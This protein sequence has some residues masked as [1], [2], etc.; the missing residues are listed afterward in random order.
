MSSID[1]FNLVGTVVA[2]SLMIERVLGSGTYG[3]V[4][5]AVDTTSPEREEFAVK[6][7]R[8]APPGHQERKFQDREIKLHSIV[9]DHPNIITTHGTFREGPYLL[10]IM[11]YS[12]G[13]DLYDAIHQDKMLF[14]DDKRTKHVLL[15]VI[16]ALEAC[17]SAGVYHG[18]LKTENI[19]CSQDLS[20][21]YLTDFGLSTDKAKCY[22]CPRGTSMYMAPGKFKIPFP[23]SISCLTVIVVIIESA[24]PLFGERHVSSDL[25]DIWALGAMIIFMI[26]GLVPWEQASLS[27]PEFRNFLI[28]PYYLQTWIPI[29]TPAQRL[30]R[31]ILTLDPA[32]RPSLEKI[33]SE[34]TKMP[35]FYMADREIAWASEDVKATKEYF[36]L[37]VDRP[38]FFRTEQHSGASAQTDSTIESSGGLVTPL[39]APPTIEP[40]MLADELAQALEATSLKDSDFV[41]ARDETSFTCLPNTDIL[42]CLG[43]DLK[44]LATPRSDHCDALGAGSEDWK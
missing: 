35:T 15:Q 16:D 20:Q 29:S 6:A 8:R 19:I 11:Q 43:D 40:R 2:D 38:I 18:D 25:I 10:F 42:P 21:V 1:R 39:S 33:R 26:G 4:Y 36:T 32:R 41:S 23:S 22:S 13:G 24:G 27:D 44:L 9:S 5:R 37:D 30:V 3:V 28:N 12:S 14:Q 34:I 17:H 31:N 7:V